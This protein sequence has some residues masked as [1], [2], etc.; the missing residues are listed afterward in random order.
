MLANFVCIE[1]NFLYQRI[2]IDFSMN[3]LNQF[4]LVVIFLFTIISILTNKNL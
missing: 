3:L 4:L 2:N 1:I